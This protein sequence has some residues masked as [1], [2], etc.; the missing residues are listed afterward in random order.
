VPLR[1][2]HRGQSHVAAADVF[3]QSSPDVLQDQFL[4]QR[5][6]REQ[7]AKRAASREENSPARAKKF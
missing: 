2:R 1:F 7:I 4:R 5:S 6:H 3:G